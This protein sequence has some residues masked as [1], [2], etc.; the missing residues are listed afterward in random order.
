MRRHATSWTSL[1]IGVT[2]AAIAVAY[3]SAAIDD[4][5]LQA[6]WVLP[7]LLIGLG[8]AGI[9]ATALRIRGL[10]PTTRSDDEAA[11]PPAE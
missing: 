9:A 10:A 11:Q 3:L 1:I 7:I 4:R 2:F 5:T 6:R 8:V